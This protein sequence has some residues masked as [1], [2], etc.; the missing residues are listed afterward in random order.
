MVAQH[1]YIFTIMLFAIANHITEYK[2][3]TGNTVISYLLL[4]GEKTD[5]LRIVTA[6]S[7]RCFNIFFIRCLYDVAWYFAVYMFRLC[8]RK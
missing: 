2:P 1:K 6:T 3:E 5:L 8:G 7:F 4:K